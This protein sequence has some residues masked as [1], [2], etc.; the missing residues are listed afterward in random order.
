M[1]YDDVLNI[2]WL[3]DANYAKTSGHDEDGRM[4][5]N[6]AN[7][8]A[9]SLAY[10]GY[11]DWRLAAVAPENGVS[12]NMAISH[13]GSKDRGYN[14]S[15]ANNEL[16]Y[17]FYTNLNLKS[18]LT[19]QGIYQGDWGIYGNGTQG[20]ELDIGPVKNLQSYVY[21][22]E[23]QDPSYPDDGSFSFHT[24]YGYKDTSPHFLEFYAWAVRDGDVTLSIP[25]PQT[26]A[27]AVVGLLL[28]S[29]INRRMKYSTRY[30]A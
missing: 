22:L 6:D 4:S 8:W 30:T 21:W 1:L 14:I 27:L 19:K 13:D 20:G 17:M 16:A 24:T 15:S 11:S 7:A 9:S 23:T 18:P 10:G 3:Q 5:W 25:E 12:W 29:A 2:T 28:I 26:Y